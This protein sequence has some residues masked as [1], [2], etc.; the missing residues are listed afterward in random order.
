MRPNLNV[1]IGVSPSE[2]AKANENLKEED[3]ANS[4]DL[5]EKPKM[6]QSQ[7]HVA[8]LEKQSPLVEQEQQDKT[9]KPPS[10]KEDLE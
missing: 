3:F 7:S 8:L 5:G 2:L 4:D 10:A 9:E 1:I 6:V